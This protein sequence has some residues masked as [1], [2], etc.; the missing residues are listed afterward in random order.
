M[1]RIRLIVGILNTALLL[2]LI[3]QCL[4]GQELAITIIPGNIA[5][6]VLQRKYPYLSAFLLLIAMAGTLLMFTTPSPA[7]GPIAPIP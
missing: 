2:F 5:V 1:K 6:F 3:L 4:E 7:L